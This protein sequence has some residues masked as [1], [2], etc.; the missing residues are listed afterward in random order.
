MQLAAPALAAAYALGRVGCFLV[1]DDY[2]RPTDLP[3]GMKFP[4]GLPPSTAANLQQLFGVPI[5]P[6][7]DPATVLAVHPTQLYEAALMLVAFA[8]LWPLRTRAGRSDGC[9][10]CTWCLRGSSGF[11]SSSCGPRTTGFS[12]RSLS[13]SSPA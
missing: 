4:N 13:R 5:P 3:W 6:G 7:I 11:W 12:A 9:S 8:V 10:G 1:N 2:G